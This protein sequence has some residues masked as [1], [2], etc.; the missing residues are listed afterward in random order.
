MN[1]LEAQ[2]DEERWRSVL[3]LHPVSVEPI[4][5]VYLGF[6]VGG[7]SRLI[8]DHFQTLL[9]KDQQDDLARMY[10]IFS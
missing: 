7:F 9:N 8:Q 6:S 5:K 2:V 10:H 3:Y 1:K 4:I